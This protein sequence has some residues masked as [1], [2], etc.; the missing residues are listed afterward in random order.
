LQLGE[1]ILRVPPVDTDVC[2]AE[3]T[4]EIFTSTCCVRRARLFGIELNG[5][6]REAIPPLLAAWFTMLRKNTRKSQSLI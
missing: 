4:F 2:R 1:E 6:V 3:I 5:D